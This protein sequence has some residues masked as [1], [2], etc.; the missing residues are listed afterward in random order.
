MMAAAVDHGESFGMIHTRSG[1]GL[2]DGIGPGSF[3]VWAVDI[4]APAWA[5]HILGG[6]QD[7]PISP[8]LIRQAAHERHSE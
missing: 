4:S 5:G 1:Q 7:C 6:L 8:K 3:R 2:D